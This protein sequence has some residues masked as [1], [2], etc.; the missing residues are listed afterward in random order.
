MSSKAIRCSI[1]VVAVATIFG[2]GF[3][4]GSMSQQNAH[5]QLEDIG[6]AM[7]KSAAGSGGTLGSIAQLA[8]TISDME[9]NVGGLQKNIDTLKK[10]KTAL[11]GN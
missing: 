9:K 1:R 10:V 7:L 6:A 2:A 8:T 3:L 11:G 4:C 5:A